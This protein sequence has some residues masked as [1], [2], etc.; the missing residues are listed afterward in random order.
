M[1]IP[2]E[3][4]IHSDG[5]TVKTYRIKNPDPNRFFI[6][7]KEEFTSVLELIGYYHRNTIGKIYTY[8]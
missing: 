8:Q 4:Y 1:I 7:G 6:I 2:G 3:F 5:V